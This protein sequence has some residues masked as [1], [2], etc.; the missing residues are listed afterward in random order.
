MRELRELAR[1]RQL[2]ADHLLE[3]DDYVRAL[4]A[5]RDELRALPVGKLRLLLQRRG[6]KSEQLLE[7][8]ELVGA[9][10]GEG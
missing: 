7:K 9:L 8:E 1:A 4:A 2:A 3:K 10:L 6:L 5:G